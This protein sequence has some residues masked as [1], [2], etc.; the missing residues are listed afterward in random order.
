MNPRIVLTIAML[1]LI[2]AC[3]RIEPTGTAISNV[4]VIDAI[5]GVRENHTVVF[6][7]DQITS[8]VSADADVSAAETID[9][10]GK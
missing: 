5:N 4:T 10:T 3:A 2:V 8:V 1:A 9:G 6:D 7:G